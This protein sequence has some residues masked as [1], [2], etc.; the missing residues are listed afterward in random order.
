MKFTVYRLAGAVVLI[1]LAFWALTAP[2]DGR[3]TIGVCVGVASF[4]LLL[5]SRVHLG[6]S[7][8][9]KP[10]VR[11]LVTRGLYARIQHP[12]YFFLDLLLLGLIVFFNF[13][14]GLA[15]WAA[16]VL[17]HVLECRRE[18]RLLRAAFGKEYDA[19]QAQTW[20]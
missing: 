1:A 5:L 8:S 13:P 15:V 12:L 4:F 3:R 19:Y 20:F 11:S 14:W 9:I 2:E 18:E 10:E 7:F 6:S 17:V 16:L